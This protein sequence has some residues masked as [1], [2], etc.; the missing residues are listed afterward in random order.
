MNRTC[1]ADRPGRSRRLSA[2]HPLPVPHPKR[3]RGQPQEGQQEGVGFGG[4]RP[5]CGYGIEK[6]S[7][8]ATFGAARP[9]IR[10]AC[11]FVVIRGAG[12]RTKVAREGQ[13]RAAQIR[14]LQVDE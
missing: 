10:V 8:S 7:T 2:N 6:K 12:N 13:V 14:E 3:H 1:N 11:K 9:R 5:S 4:Q